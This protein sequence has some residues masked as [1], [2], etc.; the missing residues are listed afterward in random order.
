[1]KLILVWLVNS[2]SYVFNSS[3]TLKFITFSLKL[4]GVNL[5]RGGF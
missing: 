1:M 2:S 5:A 3:D 4:Y